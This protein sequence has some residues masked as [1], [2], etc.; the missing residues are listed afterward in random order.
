MDLGKTPLS[1]AEG[2]LPVLVHW[3]SPWAVL[4][5]LEILVAGV[6]G[7]ASRDI[8]EVEPTL[9]PSSARSELVPSK[10]LPGTLAKHSSSRDRGPP[11]AARKVQDR[12]PRA[13]AAP[14]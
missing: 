13:A 5:A 10:R 4:V 8:R 7:G 12:W 9:E 3:R 6:P 2:D 1:D 14:A 11:W